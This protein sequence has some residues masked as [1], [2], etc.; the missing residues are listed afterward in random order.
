MG[1]GA[2]E[3]R[4][5]GSVAGSPDRTRRGVERVVAWSV[6]RGAH[7]SRIMES[8]SPPSMRMMQSDIVSMV[9]SKVNDTSSQNALGL[10]FESR[11]STRRKKPRRALSLVRNPP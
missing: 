2:G 11:S 10:E 1:E 9:A 8:P 3:G 6:V 5:T 4:E 7:G